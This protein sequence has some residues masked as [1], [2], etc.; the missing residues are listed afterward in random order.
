VDVQTLIAVCVIGFLAYKLN[1][2]YLRVARK[3]AVPVGKAIFKTA[4][5]G[6][7]F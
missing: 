2:F 3:V 5:K 4:V 6:H 7:P 1:L